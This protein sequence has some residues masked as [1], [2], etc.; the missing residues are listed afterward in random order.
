MIDWMNFKSL[1]R[2]EYQRAHTTEIWFT[3]MDFNRRKEQDKTKADNNTFHE[4]KQPLFCLLVC[5]HIG[6]ISY[7]EKYEGNHL[8]TSVRVKNNLSTTFMNCFEVCSVLKLLKVLL[9]LNSVFCSVILLDPSSISHQ[10][11]VTK[12]A[13]MII[14]KIILKIILSRVMHHN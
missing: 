5:A 7:S 8:S 11:G 14:L 9:D 6:Y 10:V 1:H 4:T 2:S 3:C 12:C 13:D